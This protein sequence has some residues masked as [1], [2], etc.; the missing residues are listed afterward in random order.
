MTPNLFKSPY[1][2]RIYG[3]KQSGVLKDVLLKS[4]ASKVKSL[5][6]ASKPASPRK[7]PVLG[8]RT[9][10]FFDLLKMGQG[11]EQFCFVVKKARELAK[12]FL[13]TFF[14][15][16]TLEFSG[17]FTNFWREGLFLEIASALCPWSREVLSSEG[18]SLA[19]DFF[20]SL[21]LASNFVSS[22]PPF[23]GK[24]GRLHPLLAEPLIFEGANLQNYRFD[25]NKIKNIGFHV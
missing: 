17:K 5:P 10:L 8:S 21:A 3:G 19:S 6:L 18:L 4:L 14:S 25:F 11:H 23:Y 2:L 22:I 7:C 20:V 12:K 1:W 13:K 24:T 15:W 9:A 16:R